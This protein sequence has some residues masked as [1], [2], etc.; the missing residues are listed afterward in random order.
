M[1][2]DVSLIMSGS[3]IDIHSR[4]HQVNRL[5][6]VPRMPNHILI[7]CRR[8]CFRIHPDAEGTVLADQRHR[9]GKL[10]ISSEAGGI[11]GQQ[12]TVIRCYNLRNGCSEMRRI[13]IMG[14]LLNYTRN[15]TL[16]AGK[17]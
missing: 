11:W 4:G 17:I 3:S 8:V 5:T 16:P 15:Y 13:F 12:A 9:F 2:G 10:Q 1:K 7:R 6:G 14:Q